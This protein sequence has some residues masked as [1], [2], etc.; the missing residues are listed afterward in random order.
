LTISGAQAQG[1][2]L[3]R[4]PTVSEHH[5]AFAYANDIWVADRT[6]GDARRLTSFPG[7]E[8]GP[9]LSPDGS[10]VAFSAQY[11]GNLDVYVVPVEGGVPRRLTWHPGPDGTRGWS[12]DGKQVVFNSGRDSVPW[13]GGG[14]AKLWTVPVEGGFPEA[15]PM[16]RGDRGHFSEDAGKFAYQPIQLWDVEWRGYRGGQIRPIW[17]LDM[18][19]LEVEELPWDM[20][21]DTSPV[22]LGSTIYFLSDRDDDMTNI[23]SYEAGSQ[24]VEKVTTHSDFDVKWLESGGGVLVYEQAGYLHILNPQDRQ[25]RQLEIDVRGDFSWA[26]P[27]WEDVS[28]SLANASLSPSGKRALFEARG[29]IF[30]VPVEKGDWRNLT[31]TSG[32]ADR[33]PSWSPDGASISWFSDASGEYQLMIGSQ[34]GLEDPR[35]IV[36]KEPTFF[37][38]PAWSPDSKKIVFTDTDLNI[39]YADVE[40]GDVTHVGYDT[41]TEPQRTINPVWSPDSKWIAYAKRLDTHLHAVFIYSLETG[42]THRLTDGMSDALSPAWDASGKYL[43]FLAG[44]DYGLNVGWLDMSSY[45][46]RITRSVYAAVLAK[47]EPSPLLPES[48]EEE[49][50]D[51]EAEGEDDD[52]DDDDDGEDDDDDAEDDDDED[53]EEEDV[54]V[55]I[56]LDGL[57]QRI[58][59]LDIPAAPYQAL[60]AGEE[61]VLFYAENLDNAPGAKLHRYALKEREAAEFLGTVLGY[62]LSADGKKLLYTAGAGWNVVGSEAPPSPGDGALS[63]GELQ[64]KVDP[65]AEWRQMF[66]DAW[67]FQRD[68]LYVDNLHGADWDAV[69]EMFEPWVEHVRHRADLTYVLDMMAGEVG[70]GHSFTGGGDTPDVEQV[71]V[72]LLG[73]DLEIHRGR[74]RI[75]RIYD[76]EAWNPGERAPLKAPGIDVKEGDY[77]ITVNGRELTVADNPYSLFEATADRQT[78]ITVSE[79]SSGE[80]ARTATVVPVGSEWPVRRRAWVEDNR[81]KVDEMSG[82]RLAYVY[83]PDTAGQGYAFFNRYYFAQ[84]DKDGVI[85]DERFNG[86]GSAADYMI[87]IM[88]RKLHGFFN[89]PSTERKPDPSPAAGIWGPKV[90]V[91]NESAGSGGDYLPYMFKKTGIGPLVGTRTW[92]GLVGIWDTPPLIDGGFI[93]APRGGFFNTDGQWEVENE[94]VKPD[95]EVEQWPDEV[96]AGHDPQLERAVEE[97]MRLL[98]DWVDPRISEPAPPV[99]VKT[100]AGS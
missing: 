66:R 70:V 24:K 68:F 20:S 50:A 78:T 77:L 11:D 29:D 93:T 88:N 55:V 35:A 51:D 36:I 73:A 45:N 28:D 17:V 8:S 59:A 84:Q 39:W 90:M 19:S 99:R 54:K 56:D 42:E 13:F 75:A 30:S 69:W 67:R 91:I 10:L 79:K 1:T 85:I 81:R 100:P 41:W 95:I 61:G 48:D 82:G 40:S 16:P 57:Q 25:P 27:H 22:W 18:K 80:D 26:R 47:D 21:R 33:W 3:L 86:G 71:T 14:P 46:N 97:A 37:F 15:L 64:M 53:D 2:R 43:Y 32:V 49:V 44:T 74:Y 89:N 72:G 96:A 65:A 92:G 4:Q 7:Q 38:T 9:R 5:V 52:D 83:L 58:V 98:E 60:K 63:T 6:G 31:G 12:P 34:D 87:D 76:G 23:Y 62:D 94:G